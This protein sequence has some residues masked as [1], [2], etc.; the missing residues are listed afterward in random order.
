M[1]E[2]L[3]SFFTNLFTNLHFSKELIVFIVSMMP[4]LEVRGGMIVASL[5][6]MDPY[7]SLIISFIGNI[8]PIPFLIFLLNPIFDWMKKHQ[9]FTKFVNWLEEK[10]N[11]NKE[12]IAKYQ[13]WGLL[14]LVAI[15]LPGTGA[16]TGC[17]VAS[18]FNVPKKISVLACILGVL[19]ATII[20]WLISFG[21][22]AKIF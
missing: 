19:G 22:L 4:I 9:K 5:L 20:M 10:A 6:N 14:L 7:I 12:K 1:A 13:F 15:P 3:A 18:V 2:S 17:L 8:L 21:V 16:W 11:K